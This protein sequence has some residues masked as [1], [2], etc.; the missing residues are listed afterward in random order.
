MKIDQK[1]SIII[2]LFLIVGVIGI[3]YITLNPHESEQFTEFYLLGPYGKA[4]DFPTNLT[5][6]QTGNLTVGVVN[7]EH[8]TT[9]YKIVIKKDHE[10][11]KEENITLENGE[12]K[13]MPFEFSAG[14]PG[15]YKLE[16][17]LYKLPDTNNIYR[18]LFLLVNVQ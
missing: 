8:S 4:G 3:F 1:I 6:S 18:S 16:F 5:T 2:M 7:Q 13:E 15:L 9:S 17:N 11:L 12:K 10:I 14:S